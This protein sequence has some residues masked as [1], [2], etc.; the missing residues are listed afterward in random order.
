V[1]LLFTVI[2]QAS[3]SV[4]KAGRVPASAKRPRR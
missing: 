2:K 1:A 3:A 4:V